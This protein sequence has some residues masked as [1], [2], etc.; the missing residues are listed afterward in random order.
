[1]WDCFS[2][3]RATKNRRKR[4]TTLEQDHL[5]RFLPFLGRPELTP[6]PE[7]FVS[8]FFSFFFIARLM[9]R[10]PAAISGEGAWPGMPMPSGPAL[11]IMFLPMLLIME[12]ICWNSLM[13]CEASSSDWPEAVAMRIRR[14][15]ADRSR[16]SRSGVFRSFGVMH[17]MSPSARAMRFSAIRSWS[18]LSWPAM[19]G[20]IL[21]T[22]AMLPM[23]ETIFVCCR[24]S[25]K[26]KVWSSI[27]FTIRSACFS[28]TSFSS[29][30]T[31]VTT[32]PM[33]RMRLAM[34]SG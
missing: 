28:D 19:P 17:W 5:L 15:L 27:L 4:K 26:S 14:A 29:F 30:S 32:S 2:I 22:P 25:S 31:S 3:S 34:R 12:R 23:L 1:M 11:P 16:I 20:S 8:S 18:L 24:K 6:N 7:F 21:S 9:S 33:P 10:F 13:N